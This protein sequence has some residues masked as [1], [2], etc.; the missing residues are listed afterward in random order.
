MSPHREGAPSV[1]HDLT[2]LYLL[3]NGIAHWRLE[4][5]DPARVEPPAEVTP[6]INESQTHA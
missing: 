4:M 3:A 2:Y 5:T 6:T 1:E